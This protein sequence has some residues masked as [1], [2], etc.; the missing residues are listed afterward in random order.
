V[1]G[2]SVAAPLSFIDV[3]KQARPYPSFMLP[4]EGTALALF[5]AGFH[6]WND[7]IHFARAGLRT[8]C[9]DTDERKLVEMEAIYPA[10]WSFRVSDAWEFAEHHVSEG[11]MYD[12]VS[13]DP[14]LGDADERALDD[15]YLWPSLARRLVTITVPASST[16]HLNVPEGWA[17]SY[18]PRSSNVAWMVLLHA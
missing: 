14:F 6:G 18:F 4:S 12:V 9:V 5:A 17:V 8:T 16:R 10:D 1:V 15:F 11:I 2:V 3:S 7:A 13:V